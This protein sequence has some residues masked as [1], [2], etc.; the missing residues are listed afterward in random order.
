[1]L[2]FIIGFARVAD[3]KAH[4]WSITALRLARD[5]RLTVVS[6]VIPNYRVTTS[7][8]L[9]QF[10]LHTPNILFAFRFEKYLLSQGQVGKFCLAKVLCDKG[11]VPTSEVTERMPE[12]AFVLS[13]INFPFGK[14]IL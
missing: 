12:A 11:I 6:S 13:N 7:K 5:L 10:A 1:M 14:V 2:P 4:R 8:R 9:N 3:M